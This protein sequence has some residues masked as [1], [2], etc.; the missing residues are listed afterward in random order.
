MIEMINDDPPFSVP[1]V[2]PKVVSEKSDELNV[3]FN[4][5]SKLPLLNVEQERALAMRMERGD[6]EAAHKLINHNLRLVVKIALKYHIVGMDLLDLI[7]EGNQGLMRAVTK[8]KYKKG[9][10]FSTYATWWIRQ[11]IGRAVAD[12]SRTIRIPVHKYESINKIKRTISQMTA[13]NGKMPSSTEVAAKLGVSSSDVADALN[14][15]LYPSS[16]DA[17]VGPDGDTSLA[18]FMIGT[19]GEPEKAMLIASLKEAISETLDTLSDVEKKII[20]WRFGLAGQVAMTLEEI[21]KR[22]GVCRER[23]RQIEAKALM[24]L[25]HPSRFGLLAAFYE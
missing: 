11:A 17:P 15:S 5:I 7:Q 10:R 3:Y 22:C 25:R 2:E 1:F 19:A 20:N 13:A 9:F 16:L 21:G 12:Q 18:D 6:R 8:F 23:I 14:V 4:E 24:R